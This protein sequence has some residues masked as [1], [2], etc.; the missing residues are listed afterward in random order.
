M[1]SRRTTRFER[2]GLYEDRHLNL[3][4]QYFRCPN[5]HPLSLQKHSIT[6]TGQVST[7]LVCTHKGCGFHETVELLEHL[8]FLQQPNLQRQRGHGI[9]PVVI[10]PHSRSAHG[11]Q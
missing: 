1:K 4:I 3:D 8:G 5:G 10:K 7:T 11:S 9:R 6:A 2:P